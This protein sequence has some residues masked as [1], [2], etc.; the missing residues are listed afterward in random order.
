MKA[1]TLQ[2]RPFQRE[3]VEFLKR[4]RLRALVASAPGTGKTAVAIRSVVETPGALPA[5]V[6][7]PVHLQRQ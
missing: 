2:L 7:C 4:N 6:V 3:D 1:K 5:L